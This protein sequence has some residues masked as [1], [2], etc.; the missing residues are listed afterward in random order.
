MSNNDKSDIVKLWKNTD[1]TESRSD[2]KKF[3]TSSVFMEIQPI[4]FGIKTSPAFVNLMEIEVPK[5]LRKPVLFVDDI[6]WVK[7]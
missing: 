6:F 1:I 5:N 3:A 2:I 7:K 4:N